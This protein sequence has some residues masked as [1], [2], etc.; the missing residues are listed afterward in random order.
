MLRI[1]IET[2]VQFLVVR[3]EPDRSIWCILYLV[4]VV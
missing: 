3:L 4:V 1:L 2:S